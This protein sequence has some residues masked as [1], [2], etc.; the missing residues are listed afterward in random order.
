MK[1]TEFFESCA[2]DITVADLRDAAGRGPWQISN[3]QCAKYNIK[4]CVLTYMVQG[5]TDGVLMLNPAHWAA[6]EYY[7]SDVFYAKD[8]TEKE[9]PFKVFLGD[10]P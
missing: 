9:W 7:I 4:V 2:E 1:L 10:E 5:E 6:L 8:D 3:E